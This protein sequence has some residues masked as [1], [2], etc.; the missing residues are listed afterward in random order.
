MTHL[1]KRE[2]WGW[3]GKERGRS[4]TSVRVWVWVSSWQPPGLVLLSSKSQE[5]RYLGNSTEGKPGVPAYLIAIISF[6][7]RSLSLNLSHRINKRFKKVWHPGTLFIIQTFC[8]LWTPTENPFMNFTYILM[9]KHVTTCK[10]NM[11]HETTGENMISWNK[12]D[13]VT[14][15]FNMWY[16]ESTNLSMWKPD[17]LWN[18]CDN[19]GI[20]VRFFILGVPS[21]WRQFEFQIIGAKEKKIYIYKYTHI[22]VQKFGVT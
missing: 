17:R 6:S 16:H 15:N 3:E 10:S 4:E 5:C 9:W 19:M 11:W 20:H 7:L 2:H 14:K 22:T 12:C 13:I 21:L 1:W 18:K 8:G